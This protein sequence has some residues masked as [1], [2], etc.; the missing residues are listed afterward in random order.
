VTSGRSRRDCALG[1]LLHLHPLLPGF[2]RARDSDADEPNR[3]Q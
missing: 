2:R 1:P 3:T